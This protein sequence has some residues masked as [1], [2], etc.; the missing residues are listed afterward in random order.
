MRLRPPLITMLRTRAAGCRGGGASHG[1]ERR[2]QL[3][4]R[5]ENNHDDSDGPQDGSEG[6]RQV[7]KHAHFCCAVGCG[8]STLPQH[9]H[10]STSRSLSQLSCASSIRLISSSTQR[11]FT[12]QQHFSVQAPFHKCRERSSLSLRD[13]ALSRIQSAT[14][15]LCQKALGLMCMQR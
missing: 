1:A 2:S 14:V 9:A 13:P 15:H 10:S 3:S 12:R 8:P 11:S 6:A 5:V 4:G 7:Q